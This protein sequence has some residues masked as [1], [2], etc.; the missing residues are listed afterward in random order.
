MAKTILG[1]FQNQANAEEALTELEDAGYNV[2]DISIIMKDRGQA[3][4]LRSSTGA[5][6]GE[7]VAEGV[8]TGAVIGGLAGLLIGVGAIA[9]PG[10]GALLIGGPLS[11]ALGLT[12]AAATT[13][14]GAAT[15]AIAGG[16]LGALVNL[17]LPEE[18]AREYETRIREG[19]ILL[20]VPVSNTQV[21][22]VRGVFTEHNATKIDSVTEQENEEH[23]HA[24]HQHFHGGD[25]HS[26]YHHVN[27]V[28]VQKYLKHVD[29]PA[30]KEDL[31]KVAQDEGADENVLHTLEDL[32]EE[33]YDSP[34]KLSQAI[35]N[36]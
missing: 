15:G 12:G 1:I 8:T 16:L 34:K 7:G 35:G 6:I 26:T 18:N 25:M 14:S 10:V 5:N 28:Q 13:V 36:M 33:E 32:P 31:I 17:G 9:I 27:P 24:H 22:E 23:G 4:A 19:G 20:A 2:K 21:G 29:Y 3:E 11:A 30:T